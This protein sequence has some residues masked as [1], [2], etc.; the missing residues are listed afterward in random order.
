MDTETIRVVCRSSLHPRSD[1]GRVKCLQ[2][3][4]LVHLEVEVDGSVV[5]LLVAL[6]H[7]DCEVLGEA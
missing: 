4:E 3:H 5:R 1:G 6:P 2:L 7:V